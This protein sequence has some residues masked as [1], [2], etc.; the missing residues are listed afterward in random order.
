LLALAGRWPAAAFFYAVTAFL[1]QFFRDPERTPEGGSDTLVSPADGTVLSITEPPEAPAGARRRL[2]IFMSVFNCHVNRSPVYGRLSDYAYVRGR[3]EAAFADKASVENEQNRITLASPKGQVTFKQIAGALARRIVFYP[4]MGDELRRGQRIGLIKFGSRV[5][6]F[7]P[8]DAE[9][10]VAR[11]D[12]LK[13]GQS[14]I[15]RWG[16]AS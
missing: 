8:D 2:S 9:V 6:L 5:D 4:R 1:L 7:L 14:A 15:A 13:A 10:L 12:K 11:G 3:K 16:P